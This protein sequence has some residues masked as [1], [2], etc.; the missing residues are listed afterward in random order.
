MESETRLIRVDTNQLTEVETSW[1]TVISAMGSGVLGKGIVHPGKMLGKYSEYYRFRETQREGNVVVLEGRAIENPDRRDE[2]AVAQSV[3]LAMEKVVLKV[4]VE[5]GFVR[6]VTMTAEDG[7]V[8]A[9][10]VFS[11][12]RLGGDVDSGL[13]D[14]TPPSG[15]AIEDRTQSLL[16]SEAP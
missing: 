9:K 7:S 12:Y 16:E 14:Y 5:D 1:T 3:A 10:A 11:D 8:T 13:L 6:E 4:G 2:T 15:V